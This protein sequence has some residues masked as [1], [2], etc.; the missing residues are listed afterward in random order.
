MPDFSAFFL[1]GRHW[2]FKGLPSPFCLPGRKVSQTEKPSFQGSPVPHLQKLMPLKPHPSR[3]K[4]FHACAVFFLYY[5]LSFPL[6]KFHRQN[7]PPQTASPRQRHLQPIIKSKM[8]KRT[9]GKKD[10]VCGRREGSSLIYATGLII[11]P[12]L[13]LFFSRTI[14]LL[15]RHTIVP[16]PQTA[17]SA[18]MRVF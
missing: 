6:K 2:R 18:L 16:Q 13:L 3:Q 1:P 14:Q 8:G 12:I 17:S 15:S 11:T 10:S 5:K 9:E 4:P 7:S